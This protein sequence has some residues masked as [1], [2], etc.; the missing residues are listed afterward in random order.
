MCVGLNEASSV[1]VPPVQ[2][3]KAD[4]QLHKSVTIPTKIYLLDFLKIFEVI[5]FLYVF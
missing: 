2:E 4:L 1:S 5:M 3:R